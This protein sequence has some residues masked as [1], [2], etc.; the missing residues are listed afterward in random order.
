MTRPRARRIG[1]RRAAAILVITASWWAL[2]LWP[3][4]PATPE[5]FLRTREVCFG[6]HPDGLPDAG[7]W[8]LLIG[9]PLGMIALLAVVWPAELRAGLARSMSRVP[10]QLAVG[11]VAARSW[12]ARRRG[13]ARAQAPDGE[14]FSAGGRG[15]R[16]AA[17]AR[18]RRTARPV[19]GR[20]TGADGHARGLP[21]PAGARDL[22]LRP[23][24]DGLPPSSP[25]CSTRRR[26]LGDRRRPCSSSRSIP[27][28]TPRAACRHGRGLGLGDEAA[29][30]VG[31]ARA[32]RTHPERL[33]HAAR[34]QRD[35][36]AICAPVARVRHR[37]SGPIA[38][39]VSGGAETIVA[40]LRAL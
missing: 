33:A 8:I 5:W 34:A 16:R 10:G 25:T 37:S 7:G 15:R 22:R 24:R 36:R 23:L 12:R 3:V 35:D 20:S 4:G 28:A 13:R 26:R 6:I 2:A 17:D 1:R 9:Q 19:A 30:A 39:V 11:A 40:A 27:G 32:R 29:R 21:R 14:P 38:Y 31:R 18:R